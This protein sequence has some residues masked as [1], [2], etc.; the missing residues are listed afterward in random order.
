MHSTYENL[1]T[2]NTMTLINF[3]NN[4]Y[5]ILGRKLN[6]CLNHYN[7][8]VKGFCQCFTEKFI[9]E[10]SDKKLM[11]SFLM[12]SIFFDQFIYTHYN[13]YYDDLRKTFNFPKLFQ[14]GLGGHACPTWFVYRFH[15]Y[16][17]KV[18]WHSVRKISKIIIKDILNWFHNQK[19]LNEEFFYFKQTFRKKALYELKIFESFP[20]QALLEHIFKE[21][22]E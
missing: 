3:F 20:D 5:D 19:N 1:H 6:F 4:D 12:M 11:R 16:D 8:D 10:S 17:K 14:H 2:K 13:Y 21:S 7:Q 15:G 18:D 22:F 9:E